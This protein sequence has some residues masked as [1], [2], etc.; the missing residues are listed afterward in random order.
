VR[1]SSAPA[2]RLAGNLAAECIDFYVGEAR[3]LGAGVVPAGLQSVDPRW[4][5]LGRSRLFEDHARGARVIV[6]G[7]LH[8]MANVAFTQLLRRA[9]RGDIELCFY[10]CSAPAVL[11]SGC[12]VLADPAAVAVCLDRGPVEVVATPQALPEAAALLELLTE[13]S[14]AARAALFWDTRNAE[15]LLR[16]L[17]AHPEYSS[18]GEPLDLAIDVGLDFRRLGVPDPRRRVHVGLTVEPA[19]LSIPLDLGCYLDGTTH[20]S[21]REAIEGSLGRGLPQRLTLG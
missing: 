9:R 15:H 18:A 11:R 17:A 7:N 21:G 3:T 19:D 8:D 14:E 4:L 6:L 13:R 1:S 10:G 20:G 2:L 12:E 5:G 16:V